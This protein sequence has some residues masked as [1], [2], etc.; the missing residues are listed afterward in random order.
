MPKRSWPPINRA[1]WTQSLAGICI[2][3]AGHRNN[4]YNLIRRYFESMAKNPAKKARRI[5]LTYQLDQHYL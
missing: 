4:R 2:H 1:G 5:L 3:L